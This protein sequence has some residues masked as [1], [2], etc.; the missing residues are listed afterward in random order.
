M[1]TVEQYLERSIK[2]IRDTQCH[3]AN[4]FVYFHGCEFKLCPDHKKYFRKHSRMGA[5]YRNAQRLVK[6]Y[7]DDLTYAE[8]FASTLIDGHLYPPVGLHAWAITR[9][10]EV[11]DPTWD[12]GFEYFGVP[13]DLDYVLKTKV[14]RKEYGV[15]DNYQE[16]FPLWA[17]FET[18]W[19][20]EWDMARPFREGFIPYPI[21]EKL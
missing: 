4:Q 3:T 15:I 7:P 9:D 10:G 2:G 17:G 12:N 1:N 18:D 16:N 14:R 19:R 21:R 8:G 5:C 13:F 6:K 20:P 11:I